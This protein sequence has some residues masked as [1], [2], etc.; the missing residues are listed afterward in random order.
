MMII[1]EDEFN[2]ITG[3]GR[4]DECVALLC[5]SV[6]I[7]WLATEDQ[8]AVGVVRRD[9]DSDGICYSWAS[10]RRPIMVRGL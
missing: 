8:S 7:T 5:G 3:G 1:T 9:C 10:Y 2:E 4:M 6:A